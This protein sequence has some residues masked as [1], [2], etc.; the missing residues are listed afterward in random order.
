M[1]ELDSQKRTPRRRRVWRALLAIGLGGIAALV[2]GELATRLAS[3]G[4]F[5]SPLDAELSGEFVAHD[6]RLGWRLLA[7]SHGCARS[8]EFVDCFTIN[9]QGLRAD[10]AI[11]D[12]PA[13]GRARIVLAGDSFTFGLGVAD[14]GRFGDR[15]EA[16]RRDVD[17]VDMGVLGTGTDQQLLLH[18]QEGARW[19]ADLV[20]LGYMTEHIVRNAHEGRVSGNGL[21]VPKPRFVLEN[22]ELVLRG[23]PVPEEL[24]HDS[25]IAEEWSERQSAGVPVPFKSFLREHSA[26]YGLLRARLRP[27]VQRLRGSRPESYPEY[28]AEREEWRVTQA[29][30]RRFAERVRSKES[31]FLLL[32]IPAAEYVRPPCEDELPER[33]L[34]AFA[35]QAG[36]D[37]LD[38]LP[39]LRTAEAAGEHTYYDSDPH[40]TA[41]GHAVAARE[42]SRW[43]DEHPLT[44]GMRR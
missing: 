21:M 20:V 24:V 26:L 33:A 6:E 14:A 7:G 3:R 22:G 11:A 34:L 25:A 37:A 9:S 19:H 41:A 2:L 32:L 39:A 42:L 44:P 8:V 15:L 1:A 38:L 4:G 27:L 29:L 5:G 31:R 16:A 23:V 17:V 36:I 43:L 28:H 30:I 12:W 40:W 18:E 35:E 13:P 10:H